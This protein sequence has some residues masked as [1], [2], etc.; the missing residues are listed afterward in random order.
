M[1]YL[2]TLK[3]VSSYPIPMRTIEEVALRRGMDL[4]AEPTSAELGGDSYK[5][6][7]ADLMMWLSAAPNVSQGGQTY[8]FTDEQRQQLRKR[9]YAIYSRLEGEDKQM[10]SKATYGYKGT[11]L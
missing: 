8:S 3:G 7:T 1:T 5:L 4:H 9:A 10:E 2:E 11:R 6:A